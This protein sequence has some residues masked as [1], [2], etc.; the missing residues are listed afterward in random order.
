M[1]DF[2]CK[3]CIHSRISKFAIVGSYIFEWRAPEGHWY[4]CSKTFKKEE[5]IYDPV[6]GDTKVKNK[7][8]FCENARLPGSI[9]GPG[10]KLWSPKHKNGLLKLLTKDTA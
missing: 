7:M 3:E 4:K 5:I 10:A 2:L 8:M 1:T 9:C 6:V